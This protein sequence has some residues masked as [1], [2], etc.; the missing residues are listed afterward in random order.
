[1]N[2]LNWQFSL[3]P[4][5]VRCEVR[6]MARARYIEGPPAAIMTRSRPEVR[7]QVRMTYSTLS[8]EIEARYGGI[9]VSILIGVAIN[10]AIQLITKWILDRITDPEEEYQRNE[11]GYPGE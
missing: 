11:P 10:L 1:M 5:R 3:L 7:R 8:Q 4:K 6:E 2:P 9:L